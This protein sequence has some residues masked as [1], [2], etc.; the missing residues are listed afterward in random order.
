MAQPFHD[1]VWQRAR[2]F[3]WIALMLLVAS[4]IAVL[5]TRPGNLRHSRAEL[6]D[7]AAAK[8]LATSPVEH[9]NVYVGPSESYASTRRFLTI[10][11]L[12]AHDEQQAVAAAIAALE[13]CR[14]ESATE[15]ELFARLGLSRADGDRVSWR[16]LDM[17]EHILSFDPLWK[18]SEEFA[19]S[20][21][22]DSLEGVQLKTLQMALEDIEA[23]ENR[24]L[25]IALLDLPK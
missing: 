3:I 17:H 18:A 9:A 24:L 15:R 14:A 23:M 11:L 12:T 20:F 19:K 25:W 8:W 16:N 5:V 1:E 7:A 2:G 4:G 22:E 6:F 13:D 21:D 10:T